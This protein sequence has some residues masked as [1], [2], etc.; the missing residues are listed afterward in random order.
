MLQRPLLL[1]LLLLL[2]SAVH[3]ARSCPNDPPCNCSPQAG[4]RAFVELCFAAQRNVPNACGAALTHA[5][6]N[7]TALAHTRTH[8]GVFQACDP[9]DADSCTALLYTQLTATESTSALITAH[10]LRF[11]S[12]KCSVQNL[13]IARVALLCVASLCAGVLMV[14][15]AY[16]CVITT[17]NLRRVRGR[18][19]HSPT[20]VLQQH[21][22]L[23]GDSAYAE[24]L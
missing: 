1:L 10:T 7:L 21:L 14:F 24:Q 22:L 6:V 20:T 13:K 5:G 9:R 11:C 16:I 4:A 17:R 18:R 3:Q 15:I 19:Y 2:C 12:G 8:C 23:R